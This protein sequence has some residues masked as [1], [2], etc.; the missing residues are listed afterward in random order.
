MSLKPLGPI[1]K[2]WYQWKS[3]RWVPGRKKFLV[4]E[5]PVLLLPQVSILSASSWMQPSV[6]TTTILLT[7]WHSAG[8]DLQG[9]TFWEFRDTLS[10]HQHRM[11]R[12]AQYPPS[13]HHSDINI[14]PQWH[15]WLRHT[16]TDAPSLTEQSQDLIRQ[17]NLKVL[18]AAADARWASKPSFLDAPRQARGQPVP[19]LEGGSLQSH[20]ESPVPGKGENAASKPEEPQVPDGA[21]HRLNERRKQDKS[22]EATKEVKVKEDPWKQARGGPSEEWKP[23]AWDGMSTPTRRG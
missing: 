14:S 10:S 7:A 2:A 9:N 22:A 5:C 13:T 16:R 8:L 11:R 1:R 15:Q 17:E 3:L 12:I 6:I 23:A 21:R 18:A 4:G 19:T 20:T